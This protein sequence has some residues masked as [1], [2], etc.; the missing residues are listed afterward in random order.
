MLN[1]NNNTRELRSFRLRHK[2]KNIYS[3]FKDINSFGLFFY[4]E[5][6]QPKDRI[7]LR[8]DFN[9]SKL[10][11]LYLSK[12]ISRFIWKTKKWISVKNLMQGG[13][14]LVRDRAGLSIK[15]DVIQNLLKYKF[16]FF[17]F[18]Y[19]KYSFY[20][21]EKVMYWL[22]KY[23]KR[24]DRIK[25]FFLILFFVYKKVFVHFFKKFLYIF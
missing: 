20:R 12:N 13:V 19:W 22:K 7:A 6:L 23:T 17:R 8:E 14:V 21:Y 15:E 10:Q 4:C 24:E 9:K 18:L 2:T 1:N 25:S 11:V 5:A 3:F 16:L